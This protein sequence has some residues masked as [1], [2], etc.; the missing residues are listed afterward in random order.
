MKYAIGQ[1]VKVRPNLEFR[2]R[3]YYME[4]RSE[5]NIVTRPMRRQ[6]NKILKV[7]SYQSG[8]YVLTGPTHVRWTDEMLL[9]ITPIS[10]TKELPCQNTK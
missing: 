9:P 3:V 6:S 4:D 2:G 5:W 7:L 10:T 8:Q 1:L